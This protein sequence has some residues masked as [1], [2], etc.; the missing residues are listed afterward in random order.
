MNNSIECTDSMLIQVY[1]VRASNTT[2]IPSINDLTFQNDE[3][4]LACSEQS[5]EQS[6]YDLHT[7]CILGKECNT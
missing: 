4:L 2:N 7:I 3:Q 5:K 1:D 6:N